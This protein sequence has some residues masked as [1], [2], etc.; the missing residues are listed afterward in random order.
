M[1]VVRFSFRRTTARLY[2]LYGY[3]IREWG[4]EKQS[5]MSEVLLVF[6]KNY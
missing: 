6:I 4:F 1:G 5:C 3:F 2:K